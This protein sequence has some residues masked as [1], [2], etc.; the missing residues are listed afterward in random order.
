MTDGAGNGHE[1]SVVLAL[2]AVAAPVV[3]ASKEAAA[4]SCGLSSKG[5]TF[6]PRL[7][8]SECYLVTVTVRALTV[9]MLVT[10]LMKK[11]IADTSV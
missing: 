10:M 7:A 8:D 1:V 6:T 3:V 2:Q 5:V 4:M 9:T 11:S